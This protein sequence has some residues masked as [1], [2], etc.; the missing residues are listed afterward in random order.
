MLNKFIDSDKITD[1]HIVVTVFGSAKA[2]CI[3]GKAY[4]QPDEKLQWFMIGNTKDGRGFMVGNGYSLSDTHNSIQDIVD[5]TI[6]MGYQVQVYEQH[7]W[8]Q[9]LLWLIDNA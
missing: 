2:P 9:A 1:H 6:D 7:E 3:L 4:G 8:R 5:Q